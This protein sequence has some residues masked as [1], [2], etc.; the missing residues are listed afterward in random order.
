MANFEVLSSEDGLKW[1]AYLQK[2][3]LEQRDIYFTPE[4]YQ[5]YE[6]FGFG[7]SQCFVYQTQEGIVLYPFLLN[8]VNKFGYNLDSEYYDIQGVYGYNGVLTNS[9][10]SIFQKA[11]FNCFDEYC[12]QNN[13]IAEFL[14][15]NPILQNPLRLRTNFELIHDRDNVF[16]NLLNDNLFETEY[17]YSTRKNIRKANKIGLTYKAISG[18]E[19][20]G[21]DLD[22][23]CEIYTHTMKRN[24]ADE[25]Y[26]FDSSFFK[27]ISTQ[28]KNRALFVF[29]ILD[30]KVIAC[31]LVLLGSEI[32]YSFLGGTLSDSYQYR[33][34][35][36]MKHQTINLLKS[37]GFTRFLLGGGP[38]GV[39]RYK[40]SFSINGVIP[41]YIGKKIH[42][43]EI[44]DEV[45]KQWCEINSEKIEKYKNFLLKYHN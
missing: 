20:N 32:A 44:Y 23:F 42:N 40:K 8:S 37:M 21:N 33:P 36:F 29:A 19:L 2:L 30:G 13:I 5:I 6:D 43:P 4:Y 41:F 9:E 39:F 16:V 15:I 26:C 34:N 11:F 28:L 10:S 22:I 7:K 45:V 35:D 31:E 25:F 14:R 3:S 1:N 24:N 18:N 38:E 17:E 27:R 12:R